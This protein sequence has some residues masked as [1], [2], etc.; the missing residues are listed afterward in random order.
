[1]IENITKCFSKHQRTKVT[2]D[3]RH[4][5]NVPLWREFFSNSGVTT[6]LHI[7]NAVAERLDKNFVQLHRQLRAQ[8]LRSP[9]GGYLSHNP[10]AYAGLALHWNQLPKGFHWDEHSLHSGWDIV[11][12]WGP[13]TDCILV[14]PDLHIYLRVRPGDIVFLRGA[15]LRHGAVEWNG[16]GRMVIVPFVDRRLFS[17][18]LVRRA[19]SFHRVYDAQYNHFRQLFPSTPLAK[20]LSE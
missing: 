10:S 9:N 17:D 16:N 18:S 7:I 2:P 13:F 14:F 1:L 6:A 5:K 8:V 19:R 3:A 15:S 12:P 11:N 20:F 4:K